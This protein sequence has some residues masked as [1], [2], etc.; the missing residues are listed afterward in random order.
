MLSADAFSEALEPGVG[1]YRQFVAG[2]NLDSDQ[3]S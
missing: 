1:M 2:S 3:I